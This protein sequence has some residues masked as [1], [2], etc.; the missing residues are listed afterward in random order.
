MFFDDFFNEISWNLKYENF[1]PIFLKTDFPI[2]HKINDRLAMEI[3]SFLESFPV[4][5]TEGE[6]FLKYRVF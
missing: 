4:R 5:A 6:V 2:G 1:D 3:L